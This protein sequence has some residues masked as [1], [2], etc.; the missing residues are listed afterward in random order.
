MLRA[1]LDLVMIRMLGQHSMSAYEIGIVLMKKFGVR[2]G[3]ST[4][5]SK[6]S[7]LEKQGEIYCVEGRSGKV[8]GLTQQG[9]QTMND[10]PAVIVE[11]SD[12][13]KELLTN[14]HPTLK[15]KEPRKYHG[16]AEQ[17]IPLQSYKRTSFR[18]PIP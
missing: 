8:Y 1:F 18:C 5:Y 7:T 14:Q 15:E 11:M 4:I 13:A 3:P 6:L 16:A 2:V 12:S 9:Q 17:H 10:M